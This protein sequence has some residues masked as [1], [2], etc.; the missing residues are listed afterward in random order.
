MRNYILKRVLWLVPTLLAMSLI[1]FLIMHATPGSPFMAQG[2]ANDSNPAFEANLNAKYGLDKPLYVQYF[3]F[4]WSAIQGDFGNSYVF[5]TR[6]VMNIVGSSLPISLQLGVMAFIFAIVG[7][8]A[9]GIMGALNQNRW[10]DYICTAVSTLAI[11]LPSFVIAVLLVLIFA[12]WLKLVPTGGWDNPI[13]WILPTITLGLGPLA[14][15]SRYTRSSVLE[16]LHSD[17]VRTAH[18]KGL[19]NNRVLFRHVLKNSLSAVV[20]VAGPLFAS[21]ATG[22]FII[23]SMFSIPGLGK[24]F[25]QSMLGRDYPMIMAVVL[26]YGAFLAVVNIVVDILYALLDPRIHYT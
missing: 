11:S 19:S 13:E 22:S 14:I 5:I 24:Y 25:V 23:E 6:S 10:P 1:T 3:R 21:I 15:I 26:I 9:L 16:V 18:S 4:L 20:T 2:N 17:Y 8:M 12:L 7:G